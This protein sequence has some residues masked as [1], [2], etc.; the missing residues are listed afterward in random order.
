MPLHYTYNTYI[1]L[2]PSPG[3]ADKLQTTAR[4]LIWKLEVL[5]SFQ[6]LLNCYYFQVHPD[7]GGST[8]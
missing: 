4:P 7:S 6:R 8:C 1:L 5:R 3:Y 2:V